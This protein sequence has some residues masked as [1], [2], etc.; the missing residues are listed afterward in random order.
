[1]A[2]GPAH[3]KGTL[4]R[5]IRLD[6]TLILFPQPASGDFTAQGYDAG[7]TRLGRSTGGRSAAA[8][9]AQE[10]DTSTSTACGFKWA[11]FTSFCGSRFCPLP[12][13]VVTVGCYFGFLFREGKIQGTSV[14]PYIAAIRTMHIRYGFP[15]PTDDPWSTPSA[16]GSPVLPR[17]TYPPDPNPSPCQQVWGYLHAHGRYR[18]DCPT[19]RQPSLL[20][21]VL[22]CAR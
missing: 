16:G 11:R 7:V 8:L 20:V 4:H 5:K 10:L 21:L 17:I 3:R 13:T 18:N 2:S 15:S 22:V 12:A 14:R 6:R 1:M 19:L 9:L